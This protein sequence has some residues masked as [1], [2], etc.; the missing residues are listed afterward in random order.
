ML[1]TFRFSTRSVLTELLFVRVNGIVVGNSRFV[2]MGF[3]RTS[4]AISL[5]I[6]FER[7]GRFDV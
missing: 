3:A 6:Q 2:K 5:T 4:A 7:G 1:G